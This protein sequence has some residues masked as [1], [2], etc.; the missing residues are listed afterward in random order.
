MTGSLWTDPDATPSSSPP[1]P[2][3]PAPATPP[4]GSRAGRRGNGKAIAAVAVAATLGFVVGVVAAPVAGTALSGWPQAGLRPPAL[5]QAA[6]TPA[7]PP[8]T[9]TP[10]A[11]PAAGRG[12]QATPPA[13]ATPQ[14]TPGAQPGPSGQPSQDAQQAVRGTIDQANAAQAKAI[15]GGDPTVMAPTST[16]EHYRDLVETNEALLDSGVERIELVDVQ[17]GPVEV[18]GD[19]ATATTTE[20]WRTTY[21]DGTSEESR[22]R[23]VYALVRDGGAWKIRLNEHPDSAPALPGGRIPGF[24]GMP[25]IPGWPGPGGSA[26]AQPGGPGRQ[27]QSGRQGPGQEPGSG[28]G[29]GARPTPV[30]AVRAPQGM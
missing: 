24:P 8:A 19:T 6:A 1:P 7:L 4:P 21:A 29:P 3:S 18:R 9:A 22:D 11:T 23:N 14:G 13:Q 2:V 27:D 20:T 12:A 17:W 30:P 5:P 28:Q 16:R 25:A 26:P 15:A 10:A